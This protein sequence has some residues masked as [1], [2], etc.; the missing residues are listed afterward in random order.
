M[1]VVGIPLG[2]QAFYYLSEGNNF[3]NLLNSLKQNIIT[4]KLSRLMKLS[5]VLY[6]RPDIPLVTSIG[7]VLIFYK[8]NI[9]SIGYNVLLKI[10]PERPNALA[11]SALNLTQ[12]LGQ[13][14]GA[15]SATITRSTIGGY[16]SVVLET[17]GINPE[18]LRK[19]FTI[20]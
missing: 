6:N 14:I 9:G 3:K 11:R 17:V 15:S 19:I 8:S 16:L 1:I 4:L 13:F 5:M 2:F 7:S 18:R 10:M 12:A 20:K